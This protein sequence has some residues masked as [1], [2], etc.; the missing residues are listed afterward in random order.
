MLIDV[1]RVVRQLNVDGAAAGTLIDGWGSG[2][3]AKDDYVLRELL[4]YAGEE[5]IKVAYRAVLRRQPDEAALGYLLKLECGELSKVEILGQ[6]RWSEEGQRCGVHIDGLLIPYTLRR[7]CRKRWIGRPLRFV[8]TLLR[9]D[10]LF[11]R[12]EIMESLLARRDRHVQMQTQLQIDQL[13]ALVEQQAQQTAVTVE[14]ALRRYDERQKNQID[15]LM[16]KASAP[17]PLSEQGQHDRQKTIDEWSI[18]GGMDLSPMYLRLE[19][20]FRGSREEIK[21]RCE[22]YL[23]WLEE[24][25]AATGCR[26]VLDL[27]CGRGE[28]LQLMD[29]H[30]FRSRGIDL[31]EIFVRENIAAGRQVELCDVVRALRDCP[32]ESLAAIT[33]MHLVEHLPLETLVETLVLALRALKPGGRLILE[34]PNPQNLKV[35]TYYFYFDPTHR[36]PL[37]PPLLKWLVEDAG[38]VDGKID[39]LID[40][41]FESEFTGPEPDEPQA[42]YFRVLF[43]WLA[44]SP[45]YAVIAVKSA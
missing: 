39:F 43:D 32:A 41:R 24:A 17:M 15:R 6:L 3:Q 4:D 31:N 40:G 42:K 16:R 20:Q 28:L 37:P 14:A 12:I 23:P 18:G 38:F 7:C 35:S 2:F 25:A 44:V 26:D 33:S 10:A 30:G 22:I 1:E 13:R 11:S 34:T 9:A 29:E 19:D 5:F 27:G 21:R 8:M 36:N 45:D